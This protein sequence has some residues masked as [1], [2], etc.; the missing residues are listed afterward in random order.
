M[1]ALSLGNSAG[2]SALRHA[3]VLQMKHVQKVTTWA[4]GAA[5]ASGGALA[6]L[7]AAGLAESATLG[8]AVALATGAALSRKP[9]GA[10]NWLQ[11]ARAE[12][13]TGR[14]LRQL[15]RQG[16]WVCHDRAIPRSKANLDHVVVAPDGTVFYVDT[17]AW[18]A[19]RSE[20]R[21]DVNRLMYGRYDK[22]A[23]LRTVE[24]E[25]GRVAEAIGQLVIPV[26][27]VDGG[28]VRGGY[29]Q[30]GGSYVVESRGLVFLLSGRAG[31][32]RHPRRVS[33]I[34]RAIESTFPP[35]K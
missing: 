8:G 18:H 26:I 16:W 12:Q 22:T 10:R 24:W 9:S 3:R 27:A 17:K 19:N 6:A 31:S 13:R 15:A 23:N 11:G 4:G 14:I 30:T 21:W 32:E 29:F 25:A 35:A 28:S 5:V 33:R 34:R 2:R 20:I 7:T 1:L